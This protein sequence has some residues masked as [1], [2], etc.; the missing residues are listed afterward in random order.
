MLLRLDTLG[1]W[2]QPTTTPEHVPS[3]HGSKNGFEEHLLSR[4]G[5]K[6]LVPTQM[7]LMR[8]LTEFFV[9]LPQAPVIFQTPVS[10]FHNLILIVQQWLK[11]PVYGFK[12]CPSSNLPRN[13][14]GLAGISTRLGLY[15]R[16][17]VRRIRGNNLMTM[18]NRKIK[19]NC[20]CVG[21]N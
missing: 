21:I 20:S 18:A 8:H 2:S 1:C 3:V 12:I 17:K 6:C 13:T 4:F 14:Q 16:R 11:Q 5:E 19:K 15:Q 9:S 7:A 10:P